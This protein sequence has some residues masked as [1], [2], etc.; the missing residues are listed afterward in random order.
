MPSFSS[1]IT[2]WTRID[3]RIGLNAPPGPLEWY[4]RITSFNRSRKT[5]LL[6]LKLSTHYPCPRTEYSAFTAREHGPWTRVSKNDTR[7]HGRQPGSRPVNTGTVFSQAVSTA[8]EHRRHFG[9]HVH[10][11]WT[12]VVC[13]RRPASADRTA[14]AAN[15]RRDLEA[16]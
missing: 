13:T 4:A 15:F 5:I 16:T 10:G 12:Q 6:R 2:I 8:S 11:P 14:R 1:R 9:H 7:V 3:T